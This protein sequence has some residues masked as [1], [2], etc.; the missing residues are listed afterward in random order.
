MSLN[1]TPFR[2]LR[3]IRSMNPTLGGVAEAVNQAAI[4]FNNEQWQM[5]V[6]CLDKPNELWVV[7]NKY[8]KI[9]ALGEGITAYGFH[10]SYLRWLWRNAKNYDVVIIDGIW[11][12]QMIGG[13]IFKLL[14]VPYCV[15]IH[16]MLAPYFNKDKVKFVKKL[17]FWFL[18]ERNIIAMADAAIF[19]CIEES[20][21]AKKSFPLYKSSPKVITLGVERNTKE[22]SA[23]TEAFFH[24]YQTLKCKRIALFL[25]R[26]HE[27]KGI[28]LLI[29]ALA[30]LKGLPEDFV[31]AIAGPDN[32]GLKAKLQV[33]IDRLG[34]ENK[35]VWLGMLSGNVKWGA[36]HAAE[37]FILPSHQES[38][39]IVVAE[40]LSTATPVLIT[41]KVNIWREIQIA[42]A[43]FV[44]NDDVKSIEEALKQWFDLSALEKKLIS[45]NAAV[46]YTDNFSVE[47]ATSD[48]EQVLLE[49]INFRQGLHNDRC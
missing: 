42:G 9:Y 36:Y 6:L 3:V 13:Y 17:P 5:D 26:I 25:S 35:V 40:A 18:I 20:R 21:L 10:F 37:F 43:G 48:L 23:L 15:F 28:D 31:L 41:N 32:N 27:I 46:C 19:T 11:Q 2:V 33:Q 45:Q 47:A 39:G 24:G 30:N 1:N 34:I 12:F 4:S 16:G 8:Y 44:A 7:E 14:N 29:K 22:L 38:F 49:V